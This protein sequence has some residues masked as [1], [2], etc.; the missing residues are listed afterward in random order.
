M[1]EKLGT[2]LV[3]FKQITKKKQTTI[4]IHTGKIN[5]NNYLLLEQ[6]Y[7]KHRNSLDINPYFVGV[8]F[9]GYKAF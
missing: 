2:K 7:Y 5:I 9:C 6:V 8:S 3:W 1:I 4:C